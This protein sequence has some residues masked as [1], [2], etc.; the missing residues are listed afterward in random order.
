MCF[1]FSPTDRVNHKPI[2]EE[3]PKNITALVGTTT[4]SF[5]YKIVSDF[6]PS[7]ECFFQKCL[8]ETDPKCNQEKIEVTDL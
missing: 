5:K 1:N 3:T 8:N 4:I 2:F 6:H 7:F